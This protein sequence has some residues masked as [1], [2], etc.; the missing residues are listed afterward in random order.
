MQHYALGVFFVLS[1]L[2]TGLR[3]VLIAH[4]TNAR[5]ANRIWLAGTIVSALIAGTIMTAL[6]GARTI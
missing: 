5:L 6:F 4:G 2:V 3:H 1:H